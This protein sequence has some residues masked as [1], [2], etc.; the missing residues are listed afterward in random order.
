V[1]QEKKVVEWLTGNS[2]F[3]LLLLVCVGMH[4]FGHGH[5]NKHRHGNHQ[6]DGVD[7]LNHDKANHYRRK[8]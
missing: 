1:L 6:D 2:F 4:I 3:A 8:I 5:G 7:V